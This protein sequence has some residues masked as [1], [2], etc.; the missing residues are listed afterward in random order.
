MKNIINEYGGNPY[1]RL[2]ELAQ[3]AQKDGV[4]KGIYT[5]SGR[6]ECR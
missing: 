2:V 1:G 4:I 3:M 6:I 5:S